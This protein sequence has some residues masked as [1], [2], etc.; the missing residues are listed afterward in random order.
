MQTSV[1]LSLAHR[2]RVADD[3]ESFGT[4]AVTV[5]NDSFQQHQTISHQFSIFDF[6]RNGILFFSHFISI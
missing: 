5:I 6:M 3:H 2:T 4:A 1:S